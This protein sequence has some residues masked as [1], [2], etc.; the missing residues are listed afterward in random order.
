MPPRRISIGAIAGCALMLHLS[1]AANAQPATATILDQVALIEQPGC[2][3]INVQF[4]LPVRYAWHF[5]Y[6]FGEELRIRIDPIAANPADRAALSQREA[7]VPRMT[8]GATLL[9]VELMEITYEGDIA[10]G[11]YLT[12]LFRNAVAFKVAQGKDFRSLVIA[13]P[14][15]ESSESCTPERPAD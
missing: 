5:P 2:L 13:S 10:G 15:P 1:P 4:A 11:P 8:R 9:G 3:L 12:L 7:T 14:G 6:S